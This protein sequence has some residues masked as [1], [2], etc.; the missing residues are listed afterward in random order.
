MENSKCVGKFKLH[1]R[2]ESQERSN[3]VF[4]T[5]SLGTFYQQAI[6][7]AVTRQPADI[8]LTQENYIFLPFLFLFEASNVSNF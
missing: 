8:K 5:F 6:E 7:N 1:G 3:C 2:L 4:Y